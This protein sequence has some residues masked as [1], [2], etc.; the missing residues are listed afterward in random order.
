MQNNKELFADF[1]GDIY[2]L[3]A[4]SPEDHKEMKKELGLDYTLLSDKYLTLID[5]AKMKDPSG[6]KSVRGFA[7]LDKTG[8]VLESQ[9]LDPFGDQ[10][11]DIIPYAAQKVSGQ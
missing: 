4:A 3:S 10:V 11:G 8:K 9:Q 6:P 2:A 7:I 1:P 5:K